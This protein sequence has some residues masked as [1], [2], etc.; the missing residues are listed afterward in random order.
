MVKTQAIGQTIIQQHFKKE[1]YVNVHFSIA[2]MSM[3]DIDLRIFLFPYGF[4]TGKTQIQLSTAKNN[5]NIRLINQ[6]DLQ[7]ESFVALFDIPQNHQHL[8]VINQNRQQAEIVV[9]CRCKDNH[10]TF[11]I[12][13]KGKPRYIAVREKLYKEVTIVNQPNN[14]FTRELREKENQERKKKT[15]NHYHF[16]R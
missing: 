12:D 11:P 13:R 5:G 14:P 9:L 4:K 16:R 8:P 15:S 2:K 6:H 7:A 1:L 10:H 3:A